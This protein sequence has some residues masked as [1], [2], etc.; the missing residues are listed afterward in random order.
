MEEDK[1]KIL[2]HIEQVAE[3]IKIALADLEHLKQKVIDPTVGDRIPNH[4]EKRE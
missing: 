2:I 3:I 4:W 1:K